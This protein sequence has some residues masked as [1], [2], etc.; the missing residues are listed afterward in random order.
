MRLDHKLFDWK[1]NSKK[2]SAVVHIDLFTT[3]L[4]KRGKF[5]LEFW[6][7]ERVLHADF[8]NIYQWT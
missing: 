8:L 1:V 2:L 4:G 6:N 3:L 7:K 5:K